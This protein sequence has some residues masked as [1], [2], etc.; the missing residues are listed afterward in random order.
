[1]AKEFYSGRDMKTQSEKVSHALASRAK[2]NIASSQVNSNPEPHLPCFLKR[3]GDVS[4]DDDSHVFAKN[5]STSLVPT[6]YPA[7]RSM[8]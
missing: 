6:K 8:R 5:T 7:H 3:V 1:M 4:T 2:L